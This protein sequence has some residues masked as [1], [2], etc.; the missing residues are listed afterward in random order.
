MRDS[1]L[2]DEGIQ[3]PFILSFPKLTQAGTTTASLV[4]AVDIMP[5]ILELAGI[6]I[7]ET[8]TPDKLDRITGKLLPEFPGRN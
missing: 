5:T 3:P 4:S 1:S 7:P 2:T 6:E 8:L